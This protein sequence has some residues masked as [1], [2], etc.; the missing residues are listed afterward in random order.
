MCPFERTTTASFASLEP[1]ARAAS[2]PVAPSGSS[3]SDRSGRTTF[4]E[5]KDTEGVTEPTRADRAQEVADGEG[6]VDDRNEEVDASPIPDPTQDDTDA[7][8]IPEAD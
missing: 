7:G 5:G 3:S 2:R 4:M 8:D 1:I 6:R